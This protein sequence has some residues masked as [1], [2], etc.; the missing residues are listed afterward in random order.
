MTRKAPPRTIRAET[1]KASKDPLPDE[2]TACAWFEEQF[3]PDGVRRCGRCGS[4]RTRAVPEATPMP[5]WCTSCRSYFSVRTGT[6]LERSRVSFA[7][8]AIAVYQWM[9][10]SGSV[11]SM[12]LHRSINVTQKTAW[13]ML[14]RIREAQALLEPDAATSL[15][16]FISK[17][18]RKADAG[19]AK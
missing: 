9:A 4:T 15:V 11:S 2:D 18:A 19:Q 6:L 17:G 13:H 5:Y 16:D 1:R 12:D 8:W 3:W 7:K 10:A 14:R